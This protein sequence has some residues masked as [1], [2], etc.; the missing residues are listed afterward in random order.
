MMSTA[1]YEYHLEELDDQLDAGDITPREYNNL[2][3]DLEEEYDA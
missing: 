1:T 2:M 3:R